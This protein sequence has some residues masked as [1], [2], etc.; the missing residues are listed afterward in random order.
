[1]EEQETKEEP[2][3][4]DPYKLVENIYADTREWLKFTEAK[5][6][7]LLALTSA[8]IFGFIRIISN[9]SLFNKYVI[10]LIFLM[11]LITLIIALFSFRPRKVNNYTSDKID[12]SDNLLFYNNLSKSNPKKIY[13]LFNE[14]YF[15]NGSTNSVKDEYISDL[16]IQIHALSSITVSKNKNFKAGL[17]FMALSYIFIVL[18]IGFSLF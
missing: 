11:L 13:D 7:A 2:N 6:A 9:Q 16:C 14:K 10:T 17:L 18:L 5:N 4:I 3:S 8:T 1:M 12:K 15:L